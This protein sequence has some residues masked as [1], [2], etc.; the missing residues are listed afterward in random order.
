[1]G[2]GAE[3]VKVHA[4][5]G[6]GRETHHTLLLFALPVT[7]IRSYRYT[8]NS[9]SFFSVVAHCPTSS[10][11]ELPV[12][13]I[14]P[15]QHEVGAPVKQAVERMTWPTESQYLLRYGSLRQACPAVTCRNGSNRSPSPHA[16]AAST[17]CGGVPQEARED[18]QRRLALIASV[19]FFVAQTSGAESLRSKYYGRNL[20]DADPR[21]VDYQRLYFV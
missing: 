8:K 5:E 13:R 1:M 17:A 15:Q 7:L 12:P 20:Q 14:S 11:L 4:V 21:A 6:V 10:F 18:E 2:Q 3:F 19:D 16:R 9:V